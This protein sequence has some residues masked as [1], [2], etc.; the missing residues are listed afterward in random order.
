LIANDGLVALIASALTAA[1]I[2]LI[3]YNLI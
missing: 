1:I 2:V 3:G